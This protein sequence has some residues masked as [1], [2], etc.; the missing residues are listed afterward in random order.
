MIRLPASSRGS[1]KTTIAGDGGRGRVRLLTMRPTILW[2]SWHPFTSP[3]T[4]FAHSVLRMEREGC[5]S[6]PSAVGIGQVSAVAKEASTRALVGKLGG[7]RDRILHG[8][9]VRRDS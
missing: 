1:S 7:A 9:G 3:P 5:V 2:P 6:I 4:E 8:S